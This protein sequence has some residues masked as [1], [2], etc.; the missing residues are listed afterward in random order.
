[1]I[2]IL[3]TGLLGSGFARA[4]RK[5]GETVHVWNRTFARAQAL[6]AE[7]CR[8]FADAAE[9][10]RGAERVHVIVSDD[11]AVDATLAA[12]R[13]ESGARVYDHTTT[14]VEG[15]RRRAAE[16]RAKG[17]RYLHAP[18]F[19][20]PQNA[21]EGTGL[22][23]VSGDR[24]IVDEAAPVLKGMTGKLVDFGGEEGRASAMKLLGNLFLMALAAGF[25]DM[26]ALGKAMGV[27]PE[28]VGTL[29]EHFNPGASVATRYKR[30]IEGDYDHPSWDLAMARKDARLMEGEARGA[31][32]MVLPGVA[33]AMDA[34]IARGHG[35][36]DWTVIA[37]DLLGR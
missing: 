5:K 21:A 34:M 10:V 4:L 29:F 37:K 32:L 12:A 25:A 3:G 28:E 11:H 6:E 24:A 33:A 36:Q 7:G 22:M 13:L 30:M 20:G 31:P 2:A 35:E 1:M 16:W 15:A 27:S 19:M 9:A 17:V 14:S 18:V 23:L 8:A 26:I